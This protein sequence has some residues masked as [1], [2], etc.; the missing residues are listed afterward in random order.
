MVLAQGIIDQ[1][2]GGRMRGAGLNAKLTTENELDQMVKAWEEWAD[3]E[4]STL[5]MMSGEIL[6]QK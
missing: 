5:A 3:R 6:I 1:I 2:K 4:D